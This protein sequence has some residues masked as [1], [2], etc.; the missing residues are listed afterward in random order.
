M[1][2]IKTKT[3]KEF[4]RKFRAIV[5]MVLSVLILGN[6]PANAC[7][8]FV[9]STPQGNQIQGRTMEL[10]FEAGEQFIIAPRNYDLLGVK[11]PI[12]YVGMRH[13]NTEWVSSG[14]N[15]FGLSV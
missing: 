15:E 5:A 10:G 2:A 7:S 8:S 14:M 3:R 13:A 1:K 6:N 12:G 4:V 9:F 11:G